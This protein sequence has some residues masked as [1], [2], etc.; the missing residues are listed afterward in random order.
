M[1]LTVGI[2]GL[3]NTGKSTLFQAITQKQVA[4]E[5]YPFCTIEPNLGTIAVPDE[6]LEAL[7]DIFPKEKKILTT[8]EFVDIAGLISGASQ[9]E[10]L[11]N[12]FLSYIREVDAIIYVLRGFKKETVINTLQKIDPWAEKEI[13]DT[14]LSLKDLET[15]ERRILSIEKEIKSGSPEAL[16]EKQSLDHFL[17]LLK[18]GKFLYDYIQD[19]FDLQLIKSYQLLTSK[20]R[21]YL[22]NAT[23]SEIDVAQKDKFSTGALIVLDALIE[24]EA[25]N[26]DSEE[27]AILEIN[28]AGMDELI[29]A[30]YRLLN[31]I[32]FFTIGRNEIRAWTLRQG[33]TAAQAGG[34]VHTDF[35]K[36]FIR[37]EV[38]Q[39]RDLISSGGFNVA[40][41]K[42]LIRTEG[43]DYQVQDGDV[44]EIK[45]GA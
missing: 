15:V 44:I 25:N 10:G 14:E 17:G 2:V 5:N 26:L 31:L 33:S 8:I 30:S 24:L 38:I 32:T 4:R 23:D 1:S 43:R 12:K 29:K 18:E 45:A 42:G 9:G 21:L 11:G 13:L 6:R 27:R 41:Q 36:N 3:P 20:P 7:A 37:A 40:R 34:V 16:K 19:D 22:I 39:W 28:Q 35:E